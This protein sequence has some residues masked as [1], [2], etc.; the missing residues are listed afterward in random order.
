MSS[1]VKQD[2]FRTL[3]SFPRWMEDFEE[4]SSRGLKIYE[5]EKDIIAEAVVAGV[6]AADVEIHIEDGVITIKAEK[7]EEEDKKGEHRLS[8]Y[9][10]YY[11]AALAGGLW[12]KADAEIEHGVVRV[13]I[14]K[15]PAA[16][17][18]K[19]TVKEKKETK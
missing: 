15:Q 4:S 7:S 6:P 5:T 10:Y 3:F 18:Q 9:Q 11:T 13:T 17:P 16:R 8:N 14:P 2:P 19:I 12:D 1:L